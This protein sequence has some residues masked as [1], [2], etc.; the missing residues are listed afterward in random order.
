MGWSRSGLCP[1]RNWSDDIRFPAER[2]I[3]DC[4]K[5][6]GEVG[7][8]SVGRRLSQSKPMKMLAKVLLGRDL[9]FFAGYE[10]K[11]LDLHWIWV[12]TTKS[13]SN[14]SKNHWIVAKF[15]Q[16]NE[17]WAKFDQKLRNQSKQ[18][19]PCCYSYLSRFDLFQGF[20]QLDWVAWVLEKETRRRGLLKSKTCHRPPLCLDRTV[21]IQVALG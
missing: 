3:T 20:S 21:L 13:E 17:I 18:K 5:N 16:S 14:L 2:P 9:Y 15:E 1:I 11:T 10:I 4:K 6:M 12:R 8:D 19:L 7:S